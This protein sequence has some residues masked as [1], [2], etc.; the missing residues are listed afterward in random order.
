MNISFNGFMENTVTFEC[1]ENVTAG[2]PV[3][4]EDSGKVTP[5]G[6]GDKICGVCT[7]ARE[8][9]AAVQL[10]GF[11]SLPVSGAVATGFVKVVSTADGK[12]KADEDGREVLC[13]CTDADT[14]GFIL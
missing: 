4:V 1:D 3:K 5:C 11:V 6:E 10:R 2:V 12:V 8:G 13:V 14:A 9:F 7:S